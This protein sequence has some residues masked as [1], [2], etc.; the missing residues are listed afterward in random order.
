VRFVRE[1]YGPA[2][3]ERVLQAL[4]ER[5]WGTFHGPVREASWEPIADLVAYM[6]AARRLLAPGDGD[7]YKQLGL[8]AG[9]QTRNTGFAALLGDDPEAASGRA[10]VLWRAYYDEGRLE[11]VEKGD[12]FLTARIH[13]FPAAHPALCKRISGF[14]E[15]CFDAEGRP[16]THVEERACATQG[17]PYCEMRVTWSAGA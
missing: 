1:K 10:Q 9:R 8:F 4:P 15:G 14:W 12:G 16:P 6:E 13:D 2:A 17:A 11:I 5:H 3:H 7:F